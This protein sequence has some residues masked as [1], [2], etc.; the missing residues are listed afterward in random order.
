[1]EQ[2]K[3]KKL[4]RAVLHQKLTANMPAGPETGEVIQLSQ[5][6][7]QY[8][9]NST[10]RSQLKN[11]LFNSNLGSKYKDPERSINTNLHE[12]LRRQQELEYK[13]QLEEQY[14]QEQMEKK[15]K[16]IK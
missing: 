8:A 10:M 14:S 11:Q 6:S 12:E 1:M 15:K 9:P 5:L 3:Q 2:F 4:E 7:S 16:K 13:R